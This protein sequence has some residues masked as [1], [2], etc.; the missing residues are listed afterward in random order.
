MSQVEFYD[1]NSQRKKMKEMSE[2]GVLAFHCN[3][4]QRGREGDE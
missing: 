2:G 1:L 3:V 4:L